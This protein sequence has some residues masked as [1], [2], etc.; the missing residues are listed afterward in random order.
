METLLLKLPN[1]IAKSL[2][3]QIGMQID[4]GNI[5]MIL[6]HLRDLN[7]T[8]TDWREHISQ[9]FLSFHVSLACQ[10]CRFPDLLR[11]RSDNIDPE[12]GAVRVGRVRINSRLVMGIEDQI[13]DHVEE[14][15]LVDD[16]ADLLLPT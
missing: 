4:S 10:G 12:E 14:L 11:A 6:P 16:D 5:G 15:I 13:R 3:R 1:T 7:V 2:L 8:C 9:N